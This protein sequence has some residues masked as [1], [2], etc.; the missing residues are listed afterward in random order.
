MSS[1]RVQARRDKLLR[2]GATRTPVSKSYKSASCGDDLRAGVQRDFL[3]RGF[4]YETRDDREF[5]LEPFRFKF[6]PL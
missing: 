5:D 1:T 3:D 6:F 4:A 2:A